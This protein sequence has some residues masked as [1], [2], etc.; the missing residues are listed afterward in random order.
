MTYEKWLAET[1]S[2]YLRNRQKGYVSPLQASK[3]RTS[4]DYI[5]QA[6]APH[7]LASVNSANDGRSLDADLSVPNENAERKEELCQTQS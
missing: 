4:L 5:V 3:E 7:W 1:V 2:L 6:L